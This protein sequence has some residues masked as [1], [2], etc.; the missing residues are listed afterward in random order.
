MKNS[1]KLML[2]CSIACFSIHLCYSQDIIILKNGDEIKSKVEEV[3]SD[4]IKYKKWENQDGPTYTSNKT[5]VF[6]IK[7]INGTKDVFNQTSNSLNQNLQNSGNDIKKNEA[8]ETLNKF[9]KNRFNNDKVFKMIDLDKTNGV[10]NNINGQSVYKIDY[11]LKLEFIS[12]AWVKEFYGRVYF[13]KNFTTYDKEP[14]IEVFGTTTSNAHLFNKGK[15]Y[16]FSGTAIMENTDNGFILKDYDVKGMEYVSIESKY[17]DIN[18]SNSKMN[19]NGHYDSFYSSGEYKNVDGVL[20][21]KSNSAKVKSVI[22]DVNGIIQDTK[23]SNLTFKGTKNK[24]QYLTTQMYIDGFI[25]N[26]GKFDYTISLFTIYQGSEYDKGE[27][28]HWHS[29]G[30]SLVVKIPYNTPSLNEGATQSF[31]FYSNFFIRD[32][33][34]NAII[35]GFYKYTIVP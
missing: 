2:L 7:Y 3:T 25:G 10:L 30:D 17:T 8:L 18:N 16:F 32:N 23:T 33:N 29:Q 31:T 14:T 15:I 1:S 5:D 13:D 4:F 19:F 12:D 22:F 11:K 20:Y 27:N 28:M 21:Y 34:S 9:F 24:N 6:M 35:Q 26:A